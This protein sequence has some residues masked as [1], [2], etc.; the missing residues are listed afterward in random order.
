LIA[1]QVNDPGS[2]HYNS[3]PNWVKK[4]GFVPSGAV[5]ALAA[6]RWY[7]LLSNLTVT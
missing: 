1:R 5:V 2:F 4:P 7:H 3:L 6:N